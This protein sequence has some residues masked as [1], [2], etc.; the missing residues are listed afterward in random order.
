MFRRALI[1]GSTLKLMQV[2]S[3]YSAVTLYSTSIFNDE[4]DE[5]ASLKATVYIGAANTF[6]VM[7]FSFIVDCIGLM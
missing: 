7:I 3:G 4:D 5:S 2:I 6:A 1:V